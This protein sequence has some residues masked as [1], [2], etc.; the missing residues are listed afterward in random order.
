MCLRYLHQIWNKKVLG[1]TVLLYLSSV[2]CPNNLLSF[3]T[4]DIIVPVNLHFLPTFVKFCSFSLSFES[5]EVVWPSPLISRNRLN[6]LISLF[7]TLRSRMPDQ[8]KDFSGCSNFLCVNNGFYYTY[9]LR[10]I[11]ILAVINR[12]WCVQKYFLS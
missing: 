4:L 10:Y 1:S 8:K 7:L 3:D 2:V 6:W 5:D 9:F 12:N 11:Y